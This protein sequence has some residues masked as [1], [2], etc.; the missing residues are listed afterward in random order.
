MPVTHVP[1]SIP[2]AATYTVKA[3][4]SGLR[5]YLPNLTAD[6]V[7]SLPAPKAGLWFEF[8]YAGVAAD[9]QDWQI[10]TGSDTYYYLGGVAYNLTNAGD[11]EDEVV[12]VM[13]DG[14]SNSKLNVLTPEGGTRVRVEC[15]NGTNWIVSG[16]VIADG[17][18]TFADQ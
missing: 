2:D 16:T 8:V 1:V 11:T 12:S 14:N 18:P 17:P 13:P 9:A 6:I 15:A 10:N 4:N 7:I 3:D 5:H